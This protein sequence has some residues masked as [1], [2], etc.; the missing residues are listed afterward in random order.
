MTFFGRQDRNDS[1]LN[2]RMVQRGSAPYFAS[3]FQFH[4]AIAIFALLSVSIIGCEATHIHVRAAGFN[5]GFFMAI[6]MIALIG[7]YWKDENHPIRV[8]SILVIPWILLLIPLMIFPMLIAAH[9]ALPLQDARLTQIDSLCGV[10]VQ[11]IAIW[12]AHHRLGRLINLSYSLLAPLILGAVLL[13]VLAGRLI[14]ARKFILSNV[15]AIA[16]GIIA[17][18]LVP[19]VG[20]WYPHHF[21]PST[22]QLS[23]EHAFF[24]LRAPGSYT[25]TQT[26]G[27]ICFPSFHVI[28]AILSVAAL[29]SFKPLRIP[30]AVLSISIILSTITTG[31][32]YFADLIAGIII[33]TISI[34]CSRF[35]AHRCYFARSARMPSPRSEIQPEEVAP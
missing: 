33:A 29:W 11:A 18:G 20:P 25:Y 4:M 26:V 21:S 17:F 34:A 22:A 28:W 2:H 3:R 15:A 35:V 30:S 19:A 5:S 9:L 1:Q 10:N 27:V 6:L 13:P 16:L 7:L 31:W 14:E 8:L 32:H 12:A 23:C 24:A